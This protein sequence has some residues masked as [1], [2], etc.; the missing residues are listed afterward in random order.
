MVSA[1]LDNTSNDIDLE[2][3]SIF[4]EK[5]AL[6]LGD[7]AEVR[8]LLTSTAS[9]HNGSDTFVATV[10]AVLGTHKVQVRCNGPDAITAGAISNALARGERVSIKKVAALYYLS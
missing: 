1:D 9:E 6:G 8:L 5:L 10:T 4:E 3:Q 2:V 7:R